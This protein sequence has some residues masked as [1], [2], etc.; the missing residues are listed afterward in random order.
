MESIAG[1]D[2]VVRDVEFRIP[3]TASIL[4]ER[5]S[6]QPY[7]MNGG[8]PAARGL[9]QWTKKTGRTINLG[10]KDSVIVSPGDRV[11]IDTPGGGGYGSKNGKENG[12]GVLLKLKETVFTPIANGTIDMIRSLGESA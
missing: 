6:F 11:V 9:N 1:G 7:G 12:E 4:S 3:M 5:R 10:G 8:E 2:G